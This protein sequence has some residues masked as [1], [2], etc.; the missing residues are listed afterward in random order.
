VTESVVGVRCA[1]CDAPIVDPTTQ[2]VHGRL[3]FCCPNCS[4]MMEEK[5]GGSDRQAPAHANDPRCSRCQS[6]IVH[7]ATMEMRGDELFCCRNCMEAAQS[8]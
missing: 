4:A 8:G 1:N 2:V 5:T 3:N 6:P 7:D